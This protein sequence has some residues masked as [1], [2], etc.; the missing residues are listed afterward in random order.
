MKLHFKNRRVDPL[1]EI[2]VSIVSASDKIM[3]WK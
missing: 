1:S 3:V 2:Y